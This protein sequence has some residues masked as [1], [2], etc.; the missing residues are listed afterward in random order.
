M[1]PP[2]REKVAGRLEEISVQTADVCRSEPTGRPRRV[3]AGTP[4]CFIG[5]EVAGA[6]DPRLVEEAAFEWG[7]A[8]RQRSSEPARGQVEQID[9]QPMLVRIDLDSSKPPRIA[10]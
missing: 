1:A 4:Q 8:P 9:A 5:D 10:Q 7:V 6:G 3:Q 2:I